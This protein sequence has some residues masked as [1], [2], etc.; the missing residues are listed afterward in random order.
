MDIYSAETYVKKLLTYVEEVKTKSPNM[1]KKSKDR[2]RDLAFT[3]TE[4]VNVIS[5]ILQD[6][7][8]E[9]DELEF[10]FANRTEVCEMISSMESQLN[11]LKQF[12][13]YQTS[14]NVEAVQIPT[15]IKTSKISSQTR[16]Q[17][18][19]TYGSVLKE[20]ANFGIDCVRVQDCAAILWRWFDTRFF[21]TPKSHPDFRYNIR[22]IPTWIRDIVIAYGVSIET[23]SCDEFISQFDSWCD[24]LSTTEAGDKFAVPY[25]VYSVSQSKV[26]P[27]N[28]TSA[29][30][31][32]IL[33]D[34]GL[35]NAC[36]HTSEGLYLT[37]DMVY[38]RCGELN[39]DSLNNY[40]NYRYDN[41]IIELCGLK[42]VV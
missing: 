10:G 38:Q 1:Y 18:M 31:W 9:Q 6:E 42:E 34:A 23:D 28:S 8:L 4:V 11:N 15:P 25:S 21:V 41:S 17:V 29:V 2:L 3:C 20:L 37:E 36:I 24:S 19:S 14:G 12:V 30:I 16:K 26:I 39:P 7:A 27:Q 13:N 33:L 35:I 22:R 5:D 32:D 40:I